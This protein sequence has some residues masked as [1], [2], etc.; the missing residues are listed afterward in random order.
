[1]EEKNAEPMLLRFVETVEE[2]FRRIRELTELCASCSEPLGAQPQALDDIVML[3]NVFPFF[4]PLGPTIRARLT[5]VA[6]S[7]FERG[8]RFFLSGSELQARF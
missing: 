5:D 1:M 7:G 8:P 2:R 6:Q 4:A 3:A